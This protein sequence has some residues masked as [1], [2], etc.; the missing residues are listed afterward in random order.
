MRR[1]EGQLTLSGDTP[2]LE[3]IRCSKPENIEEQ[4]SQAKGKLLSIEMTCLSI[5]DLE[6][7]LALIM[8]HC[9]R[10]FHFRVLLLCH[11]SLR[12]LLEEIHKK[13]YTFPEL[14]HVTIMF[15]PPRRSM[16]RTCIYWTLSSHQVP[17]LEELVL[18]DRFDEE[19]QTGITPLHKLVCSPEEQ[20][21]L[22]SQ[23][24]LTSAH[25]PELVLPPTLTRL[26][27]TGLREG[28]QLVDPDLKH[29]SKHESSRTFKNV[30]GRSE[31]IPGLESVN[32]PCLESLTISLCNP[33]K[34]LQAIQ[35]DASTFRHFCYT[36]PRSTDETTVF[37]RL[38]KKYAQ[39]QQLCCH[40]PMYRARRLAEAD[41]L[42]EAFSGIRQLVVDVR[43]REDELF[44]GRPAFWRS[45]DNC[46]MICL[47]SLHDE[48]QSTSCEF[49][50]RQN[51][52]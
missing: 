31:K 36:L 9:K 2:P 37:G 21:L 30:F 11:T 51:Y 52:L 40:Q 13:G 39:I 1:F 15:C 19:G 20:V 4:I 46:D 43:H 48:V 8:F 17:C 29:E 45:W 38:G 3:T 16:F 49:R 41:M 44:I 47:R 6:D 34:L 42:F 32:L 23:T 22:K 10:W 35:F 24:G 28:W 25:E 12:I 14:R 7:C 26:S 33:L 27:L 18:Y 5:T 50:C